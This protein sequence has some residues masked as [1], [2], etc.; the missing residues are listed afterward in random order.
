MIWKSHTY[1]ENS[2]LLCC[3]I[4]FFGHFS[5]YEGHSLWY[6][7]VL[8]VSVLCISLTATIV[9]HCPFDRLFVQERSTIWRTQKISKTRTSTA[10]RSG[11]WENVMMNFKSSCFELKE[12]FLLFKQNFA[13]RKT[14]FKRYVCLKTV[15]CM[16]G[17][18][19]TYISFFF[20]TRH[21]VYM[22]KMY[23]HWVTVYSE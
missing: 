15:T 3:K 16:N 1:T 4:R 14:Q 17:T 11:R 18:D 12:M 19:E 23:D 9:W 22:H 8:N 13:N 5:L 10:N 7:I 6:S 2:L 20:V 21:I